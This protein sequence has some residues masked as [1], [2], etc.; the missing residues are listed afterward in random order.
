[1]VGLPP[2]LI[3][4]ANVLKKLIWFLVQ[5][6]WFDKTPVFAA[7]KLL[8]TAVHLGV[9]F[10][11]PN[12]T[13]INKPAANHRLPINTPSTNHQQPINK[14]STNHQQT[15]N[16]PSTNHQQTF[17]KPSKGHN[18]DPTK[19]QCR[20]YALVRWAAGA[21][22]TAATTGRRLRRSASIVSCRPPARY[23]RHDASD[24]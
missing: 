24:Y 10:S 23:A 17:N 14:P 9:P 5:S 22:R 16:K 7:L 2:L 8:F 6:R 18:K 3:R 1:M 19:D 4:N 21:V 15:I 11:A 13:S 12:H 20:L